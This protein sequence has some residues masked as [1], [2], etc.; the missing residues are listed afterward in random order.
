MHINE[1]QFKFE[2][3]FLNTSKFENF[4]DKNSLCQQIRKQTILHKLVVNY[5][6]LPKYYLN[7]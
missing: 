4:V 5:E 2:W 7:K 3:N 1:Y 6:M